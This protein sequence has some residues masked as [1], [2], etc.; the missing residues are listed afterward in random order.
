[1]TCAYRLSE[2]ADKELEEIWRYIARDDLGMGLRSVS[3]GRYV[4]LY[5]RV[6]HIAEI[7]HVFHGAR[8]IPNLL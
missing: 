6:A 7:A 8:D 2:Q 3:A 5:R 4:I 1:M